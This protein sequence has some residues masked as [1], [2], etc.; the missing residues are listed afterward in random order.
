MTML[1]VA[2]MKPIEVERDFASPNAVLIPTIAITGKHT[3]KARTTT[4]VFNW[5]NRI[6]RNQLS[7]KSNAF[8]WTIY[9]LV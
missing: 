9:I 4:N 3:F 7:Y 8:K 6:E 2:H 1:R 5:K